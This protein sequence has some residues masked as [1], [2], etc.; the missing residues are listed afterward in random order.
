MILTKFQLADVLR[1]MAN[2]IESRD[3][4]EGDLSYTVM[5][6][7]LE[8]G[9]FEVTGAYRIGNSE[10]QGGMRIFEPTKPKEA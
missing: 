2:S 3:S 6:D 8:N 9:D 4:M 1:D 10:G 7:W 5:Y